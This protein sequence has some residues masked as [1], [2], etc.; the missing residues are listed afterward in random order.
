M[1]IISTNAIHTKTEKNIC[2][3]YADRN[4][5]RHSLYKENHLHTVKIKMEYLYNQPV[6]SHHIYHDSF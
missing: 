1:K 3:I 5:G 2:K 4:F 6:Y